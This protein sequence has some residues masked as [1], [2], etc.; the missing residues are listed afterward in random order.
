MAQA[1]KLRLTP[2]EPTAGGYQISTPFA[3][4]QLDGGSEGCISVPTMFTIQKPLLR[5]K[6]KLEQKNGQNR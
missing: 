3:A 4:G 6:G 1:G 2:K 5:R